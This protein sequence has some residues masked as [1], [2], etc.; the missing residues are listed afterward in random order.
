MGLVRKEILQSLSFPDIIQTMLVR[1]RQNYRGNTS[2]INPLEIVLVVQ[3]KPGDGN[4][5]HANGH[6]Q[7]Q[8]FEMAETV[9]VNFAPDFQCANP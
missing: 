6:K 5:E 3:K 8:K 9:H 4:K 2:S 1:R 7:T